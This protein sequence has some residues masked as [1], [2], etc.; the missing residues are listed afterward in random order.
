MKILDQIDSLSKIVIDD[1]NEDAILSFMYEFA[2]KVTD[3]LSIERINI[4]LLNKERDAI[5]SIAEYDKRTDA[6]SHHFIL[7]YIKKM[8][9][10]IFSI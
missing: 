5:F 7:S 3:F 4:W 9:P 10:H 8:F 6:F 1:N 2:S